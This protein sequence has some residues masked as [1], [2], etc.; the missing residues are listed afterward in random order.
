[1][2]GGMKASTLVKRIRGHDEKDWESLASVSVGDRVRLRE[3]PDAVVL[4]IISR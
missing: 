1:M 4:A 3:Q 2:V